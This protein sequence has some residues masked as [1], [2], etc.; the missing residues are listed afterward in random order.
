MYVYPRLVV[1]TRD[2]HSHAAFYPP[3][4][5]HRHKQE[6]FSGEIISDFLESYLADPA[7]WIIETEH[8]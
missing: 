2:D 5:R 3:T 1:V 7:D 8:F 6:E 4:N